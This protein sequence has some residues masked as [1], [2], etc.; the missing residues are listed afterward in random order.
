VPV[1]VGLMYGEGF[2]RMVRA[3]LGDLAGFDRSTLQ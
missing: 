2:E 3:S 1:G